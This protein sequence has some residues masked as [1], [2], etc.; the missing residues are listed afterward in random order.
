MPYLIFHFVF[1]TYRFGKNSFRFVSFDFVSIGFVS[2]R[3]VSISFRTLQVPLITIYDINTTLSEQFQN[4]KSKSHIEA[5]IDISNLI[6][7]R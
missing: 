6:K 7:K 1:V 3:F 4:Q 2:F 5:K